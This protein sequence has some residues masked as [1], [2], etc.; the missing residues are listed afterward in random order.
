M[1]GVCYC[2]YVVFKGNNINSQ[3]C[4]SQILKMIVP[5]TAYLGVFFYKNGLFHGV[6]T[7]MNAYFYESCIFL[8]F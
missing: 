1:S 3:S 5:R 2:I 7:T 8:F 6:G 4:N